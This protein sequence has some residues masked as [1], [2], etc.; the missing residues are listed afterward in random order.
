MMAD[1]SKALAFERWTLRR[2]C[3]LGENDRAVVSREHATP[4]EAGKR[5]CFATGGRFKLEATVHHGPSAFKYKQKRL[6]PQWP[7]PNTDN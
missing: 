4:R 1:F 5:A 7:T 6:E 3:H 2:W